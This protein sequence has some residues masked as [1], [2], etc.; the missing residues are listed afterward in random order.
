M[1]QILWDADIRNAIRVQLPSNLAQDSLERKVQNIL[2]F[3]TLPREGLTYGEK[4]Q[5]LLLYTTQAG[6]KVYVQYPG[7][8][9]VRDGERRCPN[10][11]R[12]VLLRADGTQI[13]DMDFKK[14]WDIIDRMG[15]DYRGN[16]DIVAAVFLRIAYMLDYR[17]NDSVPCLK[18]TL[19][20]QTGNVIAEE[21]VSFTWNSLFL[22][23]DII[24]TIQNL[25]SSF[26]SVCGI[27]LEGFLYYNDLLAQNED[28]KYSYIKGTAWNGRVGRTNTCLSHLTVISHLRG[29]IGLS[30]LI[31]S[32]SR[33]VAPLPQS[34]L[35]EACG[36]LVQRE[37]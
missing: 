10:D 33:G 18:Q 9:S 26:E 17:H 31:S 35:E 23:E 11:F 5:R 19:D 30:K 8:E 4:E 3:N 6:E 28:C 16:I 22:D 15:T 7:I 25:F 27:S 12:P 21:R 2:S 20:I 34:R 37:R 14:I 36:D 24:A 1:P 32:F 29:H 13:P